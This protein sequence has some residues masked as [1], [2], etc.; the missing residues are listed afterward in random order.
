ML[1]TGAQSNPEQS[2]L[3]PPPVTQAGF[4]SEGTALQPV[5]WLQDGTY[6]QLMGMSHS[7]EGSLVVPINAYNHHAIDAAIL[8]WVCLTERPVWCVHKDVPCSI[9]QSQ[10]TGNYLNNE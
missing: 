2:N 5:T 1:G 6:M 4:T 7:S 9:L 10:K 8:L 3:K